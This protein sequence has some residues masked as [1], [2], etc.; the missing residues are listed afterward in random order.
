MPRNRPLRDR[1]IRKICDDRQSLAFLRAASRFSRNILTT[2][3]PTRSRPCRVKSRTRSGKPRHCLRRRKYAGEVTVIRRREVWR[4]G[5]DGFLERASVGVKMPRWAIVTLGS[6]HSVRS[7]IPRRGRWWLSHTYT[8]TC[9]R[10]RS[11]EQRT[12]RGT[13][14]VPSASEACGT[15]NRARIASLA[16]LLRR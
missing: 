12:K 7:D 1:K 9:T 2:F 11:Y 13:V 4:I 15:R 8:R 5:I 6:P 10:T 14:V 16:V 3:R